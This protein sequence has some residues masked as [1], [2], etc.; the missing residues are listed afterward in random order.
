MILSIEI[1]KIYFIIHIKFYRSHGV[2]DAILQFRGAN[3]LNLHNHD[4]SSSIH[5]HLKILFD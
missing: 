5:A 4:S 3:R 1:E 2:Y